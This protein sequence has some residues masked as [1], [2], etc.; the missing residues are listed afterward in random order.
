MFC[1]QVVISCLT[2]VAYCVTGRARGAKLGHRRT[3]QQ[4]LWGRPRQDGYGGQQ[5]PVGAAYPQ[6]GGVAPPPTP[7]APLPAPAAQGQYPPLTPTAVAPTGGQQGGGYPQ[8]TGQQQQGI[9]VPGNISPASIPKC[10]YPGMFPTP[11]SCVNFYRC[12]DW[13]GTGAF[14][15]VFQFNCPL[16]TIFDDDLDICSHIA[17]VVPK[18]PE[19]ADMLSSS[20]VPMGS[21]PPAPG[22]GGPGSYVP[23]ATG[24]GYP[25]VGGVGTQL[26]STQLPGSVYPQPGGGES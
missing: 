6:G 26:P 3:R 13:T 5:P 15:S 22:T 18:R 4:S 17:W 12:V 23:P 16:G 24:G 11:G 2:D 21:G 1:I 19:C 20:L 9:V 14:Y 10:Q 7:P 8:A 25:P